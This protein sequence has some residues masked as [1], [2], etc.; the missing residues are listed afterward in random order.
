MK[1][2]TLTVDV[3]T[4]R[5]KPGTRIGRMLREAADKVEY[6]AVL[7]EHRHFYDM[8]GV[9]KYEWTVEDAQPKADRRKV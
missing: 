3:P 4:T 2:F 6:P 8:Y 5:D 7:E 1:R 9:E